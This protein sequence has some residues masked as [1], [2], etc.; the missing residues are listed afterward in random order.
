MKSD[1]A[2]LQGV[3]INQTKLCCK[4]YVHLR[5][6]V[7]DDGDT[8]NVGRLRILP[9]TPYTLL[10]LRCICACSLLRASRSLRYI[11]M[12]SPVDRH[13]I[14]ARVYRKKMMSLMDIMVKHDV[15]GSVRCWMYSVDWQKRGLPH[16]HILIWL[17]DMITSN[18]CYDLI[19]YEI[20]YAEVVK[21]LHE[22]LMVNMMHEPYD[23][24][25]S[26]SLCM[27]SGKCTKRC[28]RALVCNTL[29]GNDENPSYGRRSA[30]DGGRLATRQMRN[31]DTEVDNR[32]LD[33]YSPLLS[34]TYKSHINVEY[35]NSVKSNKYICKY[36][37]LGSDMAIFGLLP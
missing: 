17:Y 33:P 24:L 31:G 5:D 13:D 18:E 14:T 11:H 34:K 3:R 2:L 23:K 16:A 22:V 36:V 30:E 37:N 32:W 1:Q 9:S 25:N 27:I 12:Q 10:Q 29:A 19:C 8:A 4:E 26:T 28:C 20:P 7:V 6:A 15:Y 35:C 21:D